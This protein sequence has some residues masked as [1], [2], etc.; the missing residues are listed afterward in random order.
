MKI[1]GFKEKLEVRSRTIYGMM[2]QILELPYMPNNIKELKLTEKEKR[3]FAALELFDQ[4][5]DKEL[6]RKQRNNDR[7][8]AIDQMFQGVFESN[9]KLSGDV[10]VR[11]FLRE[12][13][14]G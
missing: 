12:I 8:T 3:A 11:K 6:F 10:K 2:D 14:Y 7:I 4:E 1:E 9:A 5:L 13:Q